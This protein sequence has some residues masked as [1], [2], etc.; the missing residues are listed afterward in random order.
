MAGAIIDRSCTYCLL[1]SYTW[2][3]QFIVSDM[4]G[5]DYRLMVGLLSFVGFLGIP[6]KHQCSPRCRRPLPGSRGACGT[7]SYPAHRCGPA[8]QTHPAAAGGTRAATSAHRHWLYEMIACA[9]AARVP[10]PV[11]ELY[12]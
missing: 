8:G 4:R 1:N 3:V 10:D 9:A 6:K 5:E 2:V 12:P 7:P 11:R